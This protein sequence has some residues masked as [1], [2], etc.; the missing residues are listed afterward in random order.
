MPVATIVGNLAG[1]AALVTVIIA[2]FKLVPEIRRLR[3]DAKKLHAEAVNAESSA[4]EAIQRSALNLIKPYKEEVHELRCEVRDLKLQ[5]DQEKIARSELE[6]KY[7]GIILR[8]RQG[9]N[10]LI[11]QLRENGIEPRWNGEDE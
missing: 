1:L 5:L 6:K 8:L 9:I 10:V 7:D 2:A 4:A 11:E 3:A